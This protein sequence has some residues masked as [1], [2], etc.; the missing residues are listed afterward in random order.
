MTDD[1][2][3]VVDAIRA[4]HAEH[5]HLD[6]THTADCWLWHPWCAVGVLLHLL[7]ELA[8]AD[9]E[10][11]AD[12]VTVLNVRNKA[13]EIAAEVVQPGPDGQDYLDRA[14]MVEAW[15]AEAHD[16]LDLIVPEHV[17]RTPRPRP[18]LIAWTEVGGTDGGRSWSD[19]LRA[20]AAYQDDH[21]E[22]RVARLLRGAAGELDRLAGREAES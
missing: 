18:S 1:Q 9:D 15:V 5:A 20:E 13:L 7:D 4:A 10:L 11:H 3:Q 12:I 22:H 17:E 16:H 8:L 21:T 6:G 14:R 19:R 2:T